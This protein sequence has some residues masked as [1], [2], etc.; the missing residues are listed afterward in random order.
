MYVTKAARGRGVGRA[1]CEALIARA[2]AL[3][4]REI[5]LD[6]LNE[7]V[8]AVPLYR[9]LGFGPDPNPPAF[10]RTDPAIISLRRAL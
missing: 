7:R 1:L 10:T 9:A 4:Y 5:R 8:E 6:A 3:G 2:G